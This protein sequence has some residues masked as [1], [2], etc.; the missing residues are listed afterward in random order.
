MAINLD[1]ENEIAET[2]EF[3]RTLIS[4]ESYIKSDT[5]KVLQEVQ[6][7]HQDRHRQAGA[8]RSGRRAQAV[9]PGPGGP[10]RQ[11]A[12]RGGEPRAGDP[13]RGREPGHAARRAGR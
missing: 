10:E 8:D 3:I 7:S 6:K 13:A 4:Q 12:R 5:I 2:E 11:A 1:N 9:L